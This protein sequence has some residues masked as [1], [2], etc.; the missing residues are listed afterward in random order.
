MTSP[1]VSV[2]TLTWNSQK[3]IE[4]MLR[5][6]VEDEIASAVPIE[7]IVVDN[8]SED[9]TKDTIA[10]FTRA[11]ANINCVELTENLGTTVPR[12]IGIRMARG[13]YVFILDSDTVVPKGTLA[14]LVRAANVLPIPKDQIGI[15]HPKL[16]YPD[17]RFQESARRYPTM[18]TK[19]FR[20][21]RWEKARRFDESI[22]AVLDL[23]STPVDYAISAAWFVPRRVFDRIGLLDERI[24]YSPEDVEFCARCWRE[25]LSVWYFPEV[26]IVHDC[27]RLTSKRPFT[28]MG[29]SHAR[30]LLRYWSAYGGLVSRPAGAPKAAE[31]KPALA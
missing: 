18:L 23:R 15:I 30:G 25:G 1:V 21:L 8:G 14:K 11:H 6:L 24:F 9:Q 5:S 17:G 19:A 3:H 7:I 28:K 31:L 2:V 13:E 29:L 12:N 27:Q 16:L 10:T 4:K 20:L 22:E 26:E